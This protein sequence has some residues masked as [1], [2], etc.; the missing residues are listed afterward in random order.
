MSKKSLYLHRRSASSDMRV[1]RD[2]VERAN[3]R[4]MAS[5]GLHRVE[6]PCRP[7]SSDGSI[8]VSVRYNGRRYSQYITSEQLKAAFGKAISSHVK[9]I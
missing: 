7:V 2:I 9:K 8:E 1:T 4:T 6:I 5:S 3:K